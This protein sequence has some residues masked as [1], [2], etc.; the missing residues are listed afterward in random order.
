MRRSIRFAIREASF[1]ELGHGDPRGTVALRNALMT[2]LGRA[3]SAA[4]EPE[5]TLVCAGW[6]QGFALVCRA[7]RARGVDRIAC[8]DPGWAQHRL[9]AEH[10]LLSRELTMLRTLTA[11]PA[12]DLRNS[13]YSSN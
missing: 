9:V 1:A 2:Y 5:H 13:P 10:S 6:T 3:R 4:P 7:L 12:P 11:T 8:E